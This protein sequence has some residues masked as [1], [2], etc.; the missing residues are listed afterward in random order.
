MSLECERSRSERLDSLTMGRGLM[1]L[2]LLWPLST[3][4]LLSK[5]V[6]RTSTTRL[7]LVL[8]SLTIHRNKAQCERHKNKKRSEKPA[9]T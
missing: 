9:S 6:P 1:C 8:G 5:S 7:S 3:D 2:V 4:P